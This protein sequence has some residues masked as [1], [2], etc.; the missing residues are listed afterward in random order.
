[1]DKALVKEILD[2]IIPVYQ[3]KEVYLYGSR[4]WGQPTASSDIDIFVI[5]ADS[6]DSQAERIRRGARALMGTG[7]DVDLLVLT[8]AE[9]EPRRSQESSLT[10]QVLSR[11]VRLYAAA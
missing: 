9:I 6:D 10:F 11:G 5:L 4:A 7:L 8:E 2:R 1:M 3:P